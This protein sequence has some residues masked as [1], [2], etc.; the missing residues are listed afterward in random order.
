MPSLLHHVLDSTGIHDSAASI[1]MTGAA[2]H[3]F[4]SYTPEFQV[5]EQFVQA[6]I[7]EFEVDTHRAKTMELLNLRQTGPAEDYR[8]TF[9]QLVYHIRL[10]DTSLSRTMLTAQF[11]MGL[12]PELRS[13]VELQ[14]PDS[15]AKAAILA[16]VKEQ[17]LDRNK[18]STT[19]Y[20]Y[21][22]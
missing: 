10:F 16:S 8:K 20:A 14:L 18:K 13:A 7:A 6:V 2:A 3:W 9:E 4:Q 15:V 12:K 17:L 11:L 1:H 21:G 5:W 19:K 22:S